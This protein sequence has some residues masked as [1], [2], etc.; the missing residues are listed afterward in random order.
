MTGF[1]YVLTNPSMRGLV[2]IGQTSRDVKSRVK[3][4]SSVTSTP[5]PFKV[6]ICIKTSDPEKL[7]KELH[8]EFSYK[9]YDKEFFKVGIQQATKIIKFYL[10]ETQKRKLI[11]MQTETSTLAN[12]KLAFSPVRYQYNGIDLLN[13]FL[14]L[15]C[16][17]RYSR[18]GRILSLQVRQNLF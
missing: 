8:K 11:F 4:L 1:V 18:P 10:R 5:K 2:K 13:N 12:F 16:K 9:K 6:Q 15:F 3:E 17:I 7:E 14:M